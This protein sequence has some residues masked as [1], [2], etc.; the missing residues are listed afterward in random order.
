MISFRYLLFCVWAISATAIAQPLHLTLDDAMEL[1]MSNRLD[2]KNSSL[3]LD[4][5]AIRQKQTASGWLPQVN[6]TLDAR[7]NTRLQTTFIP[8]GAFGSS[9]DRFIRFGRPFNNLVGINATQKIYDPGLISQ[10]QVQQIE[11]EQSY[12]ELQVSVAQIRQQVALAYLDVLLAQEKLD[13]NRR[14]LERANTA[15]KTAQIRYD[16]GKITRNELDKVTLNKL[17]AELLVSSGMHALDISLATL[18]KSLELVSD[19]P[20]Y[21]TDSLSGLLMNPSWAPVGIWDPALRP[22]VIV[23]QR[24][25]S[26]VEAGFLRENRG[27]LPTVNLYGAYSWQQLTDTFNPFRRNT[28][29]DFSYVGLQVQVPIFDGMRKERNKDELSVQQQVIENTITQWMNTIGKEVAVSMARIETA[30][31]SLDFS[32]QNLKLSEKVLA[33]DLMAYQEGALTYLELKNSEYSLQTAQANYLQAAYDYL[34][35]TLEWKRAAGK[36]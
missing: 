22:E 27:Y 18:R 20:I 1:G 25:L 35:A 28:W 16:Q 3:Q 31:K 15:L 14:N 36:L 30:R 21:I 9:A 7:W 32:I 23:E 24:R 13:L 11:I 5:L 33:T 26:Q 12:A 6:A 29:F 34:V 4:I 17:N 2:L 19:S 8:A 10:K